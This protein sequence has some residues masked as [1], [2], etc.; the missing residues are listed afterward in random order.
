MV[1]TF[2]FR[3][4][5]KSMFRV[6][7]ET[8]RVPGEGAAGAAYG[9]FVGSA[10]RDGSASSA[11]HGRSASDE[12]HGR[13]AD[14]SAGRTTDS[15]VGSTVGDTVGSTAGHTADDTAGGAANSTTRG[16]LTPGYRSIV[17]H[18][19]K[20]PDIVSGDMTRNATHDTIS[21]AAERI[22]RIGVAAAEREQAAKQRREQ[23]LQRE[24]ELQEAQKLQHQHEQELHREQV[25]L[26]D[27]ELADEWG[28][29]SFPASDPPSH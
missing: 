1:K 3:R 16:R 26:H 20:P 5:H 29:E 2:G 22:H 25:R 11:A 28:M 12:S 13:S 7:G 14:N 24:L 10:A 23:E 9:G 27:D 21:G 17:H 18:Y 19:V 6:D 15:T 4:S 8:P